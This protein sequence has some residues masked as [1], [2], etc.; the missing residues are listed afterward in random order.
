M[1]NKRYER[2]YTVTDYG[3][4]PRSGVADVRG[5]PHA[6]QSVFD[7]ER[8]DWS[9]YYLLRLLDD[10][11]FRLAAEDWEIWQ[12]WEVAF[13]EG[14]TSLDTHPALPEDQRRHAEIQASLSQWLRIDPSQAVRAK[15]EFLADPDTKG[16][17]V[18]WRLLKGHR[19]ER[20]AH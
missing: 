4:E 12:R 7:E 18:H 17:K 1:T 2:V 19:T 16:W 10:E 8:D 6:Y 13:H 15:A 9:D 20:L 14:R 5:A 11:T 3:D